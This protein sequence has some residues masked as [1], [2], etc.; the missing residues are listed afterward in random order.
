MFSYKIILEGP[1]VEI[2]YGENVFDVSG[3]WES[4]T[5][6]ITWADAYVELKNLGTQEPFID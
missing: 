3:P 2:L 5:S 4:L 1:A 6:A